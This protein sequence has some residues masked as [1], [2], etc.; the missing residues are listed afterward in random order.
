M[1]RRMITVLVCLFAANLAMATPAL[2][3]CSFIFGWGGFV[4]AVL[5]LATIFDGIFIGFAMNCAIDF[6]YD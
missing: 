3:V 6:D 2:C 1:E 5:V 4:K